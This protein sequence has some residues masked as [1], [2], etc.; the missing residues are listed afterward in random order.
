MA[1]GDVS[2]SGAATP[3]A[4]VPTAGTSSFNFVKLRG[5]N[6]F[7]TWRFSME[8]FLVDAELWDTVEDGFTLTSAENKRR[9]A[10]YRAKICLACCENVY[11]VIQNA[12][13]AKDTWNALKAAYA[14]AGLVR[15]ITLMKQLLLT[16]YKGNMEHYVNSFVAIQEELRGIS[17]PI[18]DSFLGV[19]MLAN[20]PESFRPLVMALEHS[21]SKI[22]SEVVVSAL[23][24][25][26]GRDRA[27]TK[28]AVLV[29]SSSKVKFCSYCKKKGHL[30]E[31]CRKLNKKSRQNSVS[32][33]Q[34]NYTSDLTLSS[35]FSFCYYLF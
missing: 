33:T 11:P 7:S 4:P 8:C 17:E 9:D 10:K 23:I 2:S 35:Y 3:S 26:S 30:K 6:N 1:D 16:E 27:P 12:K 24:K 21:T 14:D 29:G 20:L 31:V 34:T 15:H 32:K 5:K 19:L 28:E 18:D 22:S 25:E 13:T